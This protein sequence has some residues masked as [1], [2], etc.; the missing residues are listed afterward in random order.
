MHHTTLNQIRA[1]LEGMPLKKNNPVVF[2]HSSLFPFGLI[3]GGVSGICETLIDWVGHSGTILMPTFTFRKADA[4]HEHNTPSETGVLTE[5]FRKLP[6]VRRTIHPIHSVAAYGRQAEYLT[7]E[8]DSSSFGPKSVFAKMFELKATNISLGTEFEGGATYLHYIEELAKVPYRDYV[9]LNQTVFNSM[10]DKSDENFKYFA[11]IKE[12]NFEWDNNW[13]PIWDDFIAH[14]MIQLKKIGPA[15]IMY[16]DMHQA[17]N[18]FLQKLN[19]N[20]FY[21]AVKR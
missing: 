15:K 18:F 14:G 4:W 11:R 3:E 7:S 16:S 21:C 5:Y 19:K 17:G 8:I 20:P 1:I 9:K 6:R 12:N 13:L 10:G 2:V